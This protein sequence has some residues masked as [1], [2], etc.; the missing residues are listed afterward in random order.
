MAAALQTGRTASSELEVVSP[1]LVLIDPKLAA[2]AR[3]LL[4]DPAEPDRQP[5]EAKRA[6]P[7]S[8]AAA[9][10]PPPGD[11]NAEARQRLMERGLDSEV[12]GE[13]VPSEKHFRGRALFIPAAAAATAVALFVVQLYL[14][15]GKLG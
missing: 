1:E 2:D 4:G 14:S 6:A 10:P 15:Q 11:T 12:L 9:P 3:E 7:S 13:L 5:L 8:P